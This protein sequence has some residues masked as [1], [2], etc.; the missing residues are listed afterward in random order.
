[1]GIP[2]SDGEALPIATDPFAQRLRVIFVQAVGGGGPNGRLAGGVA[3]AVSIAREWSGSCCQVLFVTNASD[4]YHKGNSSP[5]EVRTLPSALRHSNSPA[6]FMLQMLINPILQVRAL[7]E[8]VQGEEFEQPGVVLAVSPYLADVI[9][10][11]RV[12]RKTHYPCVIFFHHI[13]P[14]AL[15]HYQRRGGLLRTILARLTTIIGVVCA[16]V[17]GLQ[18]ALCSSREPSLGWL[19]VPQPRVMIENS[20]GPKMSEVPSLSRSRELEVCYVGRIA[21]NKGIFDL[22]D[23]W[24]DI[25]R[26]YS[27]AILHVVGQATDPLALAKFHGLINKYGYASSVN[28]HGFVP[29]SE[30][31]RILSLCRA[32][33]IPSYEEGWSIAA[34]EGAARGATPIAYDLPAYDWLEELVIRVKIG[35]RRALASAIASVFS[36]EIDHSKVMDRARAILDHY[37]SAS[38]AARE[39]SQLRS[40]VAEN[41]RSK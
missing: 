18:L 5:Y 23:S 41:S 39:F 13:T 32:I 19:R 10:S 30:L 33:V 27:E 17:F 4:E 7:G 28:Y 11:I 40:I 14:P 20:I 1:M 15:W 6:A 8:I 29:D 38:V 35:D 9:D 36:K 34:M 3:H 12:S 22:L 37:S 31:S 25:H 24:T 21:P 2:V 26:A 16:K